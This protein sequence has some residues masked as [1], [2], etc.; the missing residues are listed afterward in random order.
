MSDSRHFMTDTLL[1]DGSVFLAG[2]YPDNDQVT[3]L[4]WVYHP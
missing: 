3:A 2:G 4:S 1:N